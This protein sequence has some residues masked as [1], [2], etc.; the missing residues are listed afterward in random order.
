[1]RIGIDAR[2]VL[3]KRT[4]VGNYTYN[5][6]KNLSRID[7]ENQ[8]VLFYS[9]H[10][11]VRSAIPRFDNPNF[12]TRYFRIPNKLL[13][14]MWGT[15]R[16]PKIDWLVGRVDLYHSP[17]YNLNILGHG[18]SVITI[19]DLN[20]LALREHSIYTAKWYYA[21]KIKDYAHQADAVIVVSESTKREVLKYLEVPGKKVHVIYNGYSP[22]FRP[23]VENENT[24]KVLDKYRIKG[25][26][27]LF[28]GTLEPRKNIEGVIRAYHQ[29]KAKEDFLLVLA[30]GRGWKYKTVF[31]LLEELK[32]KNRVV[33]TWY[34]PESDLPALYNQAS[35]FVYPSFY[36]GFGIPPL[37][38][39]ACGLPV[40]VSNTTSMP[41]V[42]GDAGLY[43][44]PHDVKQISHSIDTVLSDDQLRNS[45]KEKGLER[46]EMFSWE[47]TAREILKLY[48]Q[49]VRE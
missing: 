46:A 39:M 47:K 19:H 25:D 2:S 14:L 7:K 23:L 10:K 40:I 49:L 1:M 18:K 5:I 3:K 21:Y 43:V 44:D 38:A 24:K 37:E 8:Y 33:F 22:A 13:N 31:G 27:I 4:G 11:N 16:M 41:E 42:V 6:A 26:Y 34:V 29:C 15:F 17:N 12:E 35:L 20:F 32:L 48:Q 28:V 9:H 45:M 36:E 30:G